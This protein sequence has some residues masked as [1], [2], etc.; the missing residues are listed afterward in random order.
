MGILPVE[1]RR[2]LAVPLGGQG[3][4]CALVAQAIGKVR[5]CLVYFRNS[6]EGKCILQRMNSD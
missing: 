5:I 1:G 6:S 3:V 4:P 2:T